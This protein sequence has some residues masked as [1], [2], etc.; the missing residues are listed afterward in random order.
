MM[1]SGSIP[2]SRPICSMVWYS[3]LAMTLTTSVSEAQPRT[4]P[5][6]ALHASPRSSL[7][8]VD[9][10]PRPH[11]DG[12]RDPDH[13]VVRA[14]DAQPLGGAAHQDAVKMAPPADR[15]ARLDDHRAAGVPP[16]VVV[17]PDRAVDPGRRNLEHVVR[18]ERVGLVE[19]RLERGADLG[20]IL[21]PH[22]V[23]PR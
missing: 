14:A 4:L 15:L 10:L 13:L 8:E 18:A 1:T 7:L 20:A 9:L 2:F 16:D 22:S 3:S 23:R 19:R 12:A 17:R 6:S 11:D 5:R 21:E